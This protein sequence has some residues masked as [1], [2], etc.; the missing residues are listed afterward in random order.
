M[1]TGTQDKQD[2]IK[3]LEDR[4]LFWQ[5]ENHKVTKQLKFWIEV[6]VVEGLIL[7]MFVVAYF[8]QRS[9]LPG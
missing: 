3:E 8:Y 4:L 5:E 9:S 2:E 7:F 6:A 1:M